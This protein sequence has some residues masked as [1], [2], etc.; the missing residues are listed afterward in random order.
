MS[1]F[2]AVYLE[3]LERQINE[4]TNLRRKEFLKKGL[5]RGTTDFLRYI[6]YPAIGNLNDLYPEYEVRDFNNGFRYLDL[7]YMPGNAKGCIEIQDY[8]SHARDI[9]AGRFKDLCMKQAL[10]A[11]D[12]WLFLPI[13]Y[14][15]IREDPG[16]CKQLVLSFVGKFLSNAVPSNLHWAEAEAL[17]FARRLMRPFTPGE[18]ADHLRLSKQHT[19]AILRAMHS[20]KLLEVAGGRQRYRTFRLPSAR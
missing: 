1:E 4:E 9:E 11:L 6:W 7:A 17:R 2:D 16:V 13:A 18:L 19:R 20:R 14:L 8:R 10:L 12:D 3:W 5:S 15:S